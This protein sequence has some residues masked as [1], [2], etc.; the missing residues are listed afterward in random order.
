MNRYSVQLEIAGPLAMFSRP[1]TGGTPVSYPMP[2]FSACKG[3]FETIAWLNRGA[4]IKPIKVEICKAK[5][6]PGGR[7]NFQSYANNYG[8]P[9]RKADQIANGNSF[10]YFNQIL[11]NVCY[12][13][14]GDVVANETAP[15]RKGENSRHYLEHLFNRRLRQGRCFRTPCLG[16]SEFTAN[17]W[18][19]FRDSFEVD[20]DLDGLRIGAMLKSVWSAPI[21]GSYDPKFEQELAVEKGVLTFA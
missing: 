7:I 2:T 4:W 20:Q 9:L 17:Y 21:H 5:N 19:P 3:I 15:D 18:G 13:L 1:D 6:R 10:Q 11:T 12:R 14:Y 16:L 8:G